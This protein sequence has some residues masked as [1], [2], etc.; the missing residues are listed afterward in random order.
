MTESKL[1]GERQKLATQYAEAHEALIAAQKKC[2][3][4]K[5]IIVVFDEEYPEVMLVVKEYQK[6]T[7]LAEVAEKRAAEE[8]TAGSEQ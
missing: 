7:K 4:A 6:N 3:D 1:L 2:A 5:R 8:E